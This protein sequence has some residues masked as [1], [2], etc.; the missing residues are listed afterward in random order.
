MDVVLA[1]SNPGKVREA[2]AILEAAGLT[3]ATIPMWL[4]DIESGTTYLEN[5]RIKASSALRV[6]G[7]AV[8]AEDAGLEVDAL[9]GLP[10]VRSARF[11]GPG[12]TADDNN[13]KLVRLMDGVPAEERTA[14]YRAVAVLLLPSGEELIGHGV[15]EGCIADKPR[16]DA[17]FGYDPLFVPEGYDRTAAELSEDEKNEISHRARA[18]REIVT[19]TAER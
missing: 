1:T 16:G 11:A 8:L 3:V 10:G 5:A 18:L 15:L 14:R 9:R 17:G 12:A 13:E 6:V 4:G 7:R 19:R 2:R